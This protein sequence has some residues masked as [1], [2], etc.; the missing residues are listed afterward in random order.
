MNET[1]QQQA[2]QKLVEGFLKI[3]GMRRGLQSNLRTTRQELARSQA[4]YAYGTE[5]DI[6]SALGYPSD[7][8]YENY[9]AWYR[10]DPIAKRIINIPVN[11]TWSGDIEITEDDKLETPFEKDVNSLIKKLKIIRQ[12]RWAD[13]LAGLGK[14]S[15]LFIGF[16]GDGDLTEPPQKNSTIIYTRPYPEKSVQ[17]AAYVEDTSDERYGLPESYNLTFRS[18]KAGQS[19]Y[20]QRVHWSRIIHIAEEYLDDEVEGTPR[21]ECVFNLLIAMLLVVGGSAESFWRLAFPGYAFAHDEGTIMGDLD[22]FKERVEDWIHQFERYIRVQGMKVE[23]FS[24]NVASPKDNV[25]AIFQL[26]SVGTGIPKRLLTGSEIGERSSQQDRK[27]WSDVIQERRINYAEPTIFRPF[28]DRAIEFGAVKSPRSIDEG[29]SI[30]WPPD[31]SPSEDEQANTAKTRVGTMG[32]YVSRGV[33]TILPLRTF[34]TTEMGYSEK[35]VDSIEEGL[36]AQFEEERRLEQ[37]Q[38]EELER[39]QRQQQMDEQNQGGLVL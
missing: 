31:Y 36:T 33:E 35:E 9:E 19:N 11:A 34:L 8:S 2:A 7:I 12:F 16:S 3:E 23:Q 15:V 17:V 26:L 10:R 20:T 32:D 1:E 29:Y 22:D 39:Q 27:N 38:Q 5:R 28:I 6:F 24:P 14:F 25:D 30:Y 37:E 21:L 4:G 18:P 13:R